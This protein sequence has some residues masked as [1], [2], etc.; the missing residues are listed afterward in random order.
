MSSNIRPEVPVVC[1]DVNVNLR[2]STPC[3]SFQFRIKTGSHNLAK[4]S[5]SVSE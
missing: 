1:S 3:P 4:K 2:K 5:F